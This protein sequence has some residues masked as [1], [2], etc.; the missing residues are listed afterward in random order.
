MSMTIPGTLIVSS[1]YKDT[2]TLNECWEIVCL[3]SNRVVFADLDCLTCHRVDLR[4]RAK[5]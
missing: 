5:P 4:Y 3:T 1:I 2:V